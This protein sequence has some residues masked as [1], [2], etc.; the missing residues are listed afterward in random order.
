MLLKK[1]LFCSIC[2]CEVPSAIIYQITLGTYLGKLCRKVALRSCHL[3]LS[4]K[5][6]FR[7]LLKVVIEKL[8]EKKRTLIALRHWKI[9]LTD[10]FE[11]LS[12][13]MWLPGKVTLRDEV[14]KSP[15]EVA[16]R[17]C[18]DWKCRL[19]CL[20]MIPWKIVLTKFQFFKWSS[21]KEF[22]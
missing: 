9:A 10:C 22:L 15:T 20:E 14:L 2:R 11:K 4:L 5:L 18:H 1:Y 21:F 8:L 6:L 17:V 16:L 12:S 7:S 13:K 3:T 19:D